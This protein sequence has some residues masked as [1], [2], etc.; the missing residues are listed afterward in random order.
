M[1]IRQNR[2]QWVFKRQL[3]KVRNLCY[4]IIEFLSKLDTYILN[5]QSLGKCSTL[6]PSLYIR[7]N[8][9]WGKEKTNTRTHWYLIEALELKSRSLATHLCLLP[10]FF[11]PIACFSQKLNGMV[12]KQKTSAWLFKSLVFF[13]LI[14]SPLSAYSLSY[15]SSLTLLIRGLGHSYLTCNLHPLKA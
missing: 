7:G 9:S 10:G 13:S 8:W 2:C 3:R 11:M 14:C 5:Y 12:F 4:K 6:N 1:N 15:L